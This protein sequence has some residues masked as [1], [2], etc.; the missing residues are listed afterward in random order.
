MKHLKLYEQYF[1]LEES[2]FW[3]NKAS[4]V[5]PIAKDT[6]RI[7]IGLRS[8]YV[9]EPNTWGNFGGAIGLD[10]YGRDESELSPSDNAKKE[11]M[12]EIG[13]NGDMEMVDSYIFE[14][15]G[16]IYYNFLGLIQN[17]DSISNLNTNLNWEVD[18]IKWV[19]FEELKA[20]PELHFG[21][22]G[23]IGNA[24][25]QIENLINKFSA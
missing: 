16:F 11:M 14:T 15:D 9:N 12:E 2:G 25:E 13:F 23:L 1:K 18:E 5:L 3:G 4:G 22:E 24:E 21:L 7:L 20:H 8:D 10:D 17:E 19:T 6:G